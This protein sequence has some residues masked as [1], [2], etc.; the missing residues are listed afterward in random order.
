MDDDEK[1]T[2]TMS[3]RR[4][5]EIFGEG[6]VGK[7]KDKLGKVEDDEETPMVNK[8]LPMEMQDWTGE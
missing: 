7:W 4:A 3:V 1:V 8:N 2:I 5:K 6:V